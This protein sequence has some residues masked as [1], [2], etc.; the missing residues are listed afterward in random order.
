MKLNAKWHKKNKNAEK[1]EPRGKN[2]VALRT[3]EILCLPA[4]V[5]KAKKRDK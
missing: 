4:D 3:C 2:Q 5:R 1:S